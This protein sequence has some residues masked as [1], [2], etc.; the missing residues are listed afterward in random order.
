[1]KICSKCNIE[2]NESEFYYIASKGI[3]RGDCKSCNSAKASKWNKENPSKRSVNGRKNRLKALYGMTE[4]QFNQ[5]KANQG[6]GC[7]ICERKLKLVV[8]HDH[9]TGK[10]R[11]LLCNSCNRGIGYLQDSENI[12]KRAMVYVI[13]NS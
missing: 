3:Y 12:L 11:G 1:M 8:D 13:K 10:I 6:N 2:K 9:D 5:M 7:A 4:E